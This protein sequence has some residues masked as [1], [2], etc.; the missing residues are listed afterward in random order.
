[1]APL[2]PCELGLGSK[3]LDV[4]EERTEAE[5]LVVVGRRDGDAHDALGAPEERDG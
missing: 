5:R 4:G 3:L 1:M 2:G